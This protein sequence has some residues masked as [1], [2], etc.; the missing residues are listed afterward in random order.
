MKFLGSLAILLALGATALG[1]ATAPGS[2][3]IQLQAVPRGVHPAVVRVIAPEHNGMS[4]GSGT[5]VAVAGDHGLVVTNW[6][7]VRDATSTVEVRF[8][9]GFRSPA[10][11]L[12]MDREWDLAALAI[13]RPPVEPVRLST[14]PPRPGDRLTIAGY[15]SGPYRAVTGA[16]TQY[17]A[18]DSG[19]PFEMVELSV[20]ARQGDS[21]GPIFNQQGELA[22]VLFGSGLGCTSGSYCGRVQQ[23]LAS[24]EGDF[25][26]LTPNPLMIAQQTPQA[27]QPAPA[28]PAASQ[29]SAPPATATASNWKP[30]SR[31]LG[32][33]YTAP[34]TN[35]LATS[36]PPRPEPVP[37]ATAAAP[38]AA[39]YWPAPEPAPRAPAA[40][41]PPPPTATPVAAIATTAAPA[42]S[43]PASAV[44]PVAATVRQDASADLV[45][46]SAFD[47]IKTL[48]AAIGAFAIFF[49]AVRVL[50]LTSEGQAAG[51]AGKKKKA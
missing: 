11:V 9:N 50:A 41:L 32:N 22:G 36:P 45:G 40:P 21:G 3:P 27:T 19:R 8:P 24:V 10:T 25:R 6:H 20:A 7:V 39:N 12:R 48:L 29:P 5:L 1:Q 23:F 28:T 34:P 15:G 43:L 33:P 49:H 2:L 51:K 30:A 13:W 14:T 35:T 18:P 38:P 44:V 37:Q 31:P 17:V 16:C 4:M 46:T 26:R 42:A 47:Q